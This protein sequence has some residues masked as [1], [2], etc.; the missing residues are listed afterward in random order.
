MKLYFLQIVPMKKCYTG[1]TAECGGEYRVCTGEDLGVEGEIAGVPCKF[2]TNFDPTYP[3][4]LGGLLNVEE[5]IGYVQVKDLS[6]YFQYFFSF[7]F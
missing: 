1:R 2:V 6:H 4:I 3:V 5:N 7:H